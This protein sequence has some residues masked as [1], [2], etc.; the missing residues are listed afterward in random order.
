MTSGLDVAP[1]RCHGDEGKP[2]AARPGESG[3]GIRQSLLGVP[4]VV[5]VRRPRA[6]SGSGA[7]GCVVLFVSVSSFILVAFAACWLE[8]GGGG[9]RNEK[10][11]RK[12]ILKKGRGRREGKEGNDK[13][14]RSLSF[15][16]MAVSRD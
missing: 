15:R 14:S 1:G 3:R 13:K 8:D 5:L 2:P 16:Q 9:Q 6:A 12:P 10:G 4:A 11:K 7:D